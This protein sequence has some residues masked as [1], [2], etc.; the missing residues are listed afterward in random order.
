MLAAKASIERTLDEVIARI[1]WG[2]LLM[3]SMKDGDYLELYRQRWTEGYTYALWRQGIM[4]GNDA[5]AEAQ[6]VWKLGPGD[7]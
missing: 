5:K 7:E 3:L 6:R 2:A 1:P 4:T